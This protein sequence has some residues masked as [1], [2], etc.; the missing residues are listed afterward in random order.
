MEFVKYIQRLQSKITKL[1]LISVYN[2]YLCLGCQATKNCTV[3]DL[4]ALLKPNSVL[5][6]HHNSA[7]LLGG[8]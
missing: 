3:Y 6:V 1:Y 2:L 8:F 5:F 7:L 4:K